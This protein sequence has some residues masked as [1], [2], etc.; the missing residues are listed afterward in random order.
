MQLRSQENSTQ[1]HQ[2]PCYQDG[3]REVFVLFMVL[4]LMS[5]WLR[6]Q[7]IKSQ[8][9]RG[10]GLPSGMQSGGSQMTTGPQE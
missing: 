2:K 4:M 1:M 5:I 10:S 7:V 3:A 6:F 9:G 8:T